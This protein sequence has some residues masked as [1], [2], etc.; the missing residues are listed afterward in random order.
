MQMVK[1]NL[2]L[3]EET[4]FIVFSDINC[5]LLQHAYKSNI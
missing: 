4:I 3:E 5:Y 1:R 2:W